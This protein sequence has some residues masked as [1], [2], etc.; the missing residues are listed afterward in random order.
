[1][2]HFHAVTSNTLQCY[3]TQPKSRCTYYS[4]HLISTQ[5]IKISQRKKKHSQTKISY[6]KT[7]Y[8]DANFLIKVKILSSNYIINSI[9]YT[10]KGKSKLHKNIIYT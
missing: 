10:F 7:N 6:S 4:N 2:R 9:K 8:Y 3:D 1:M 5:S